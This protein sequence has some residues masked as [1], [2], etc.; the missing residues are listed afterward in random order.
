MIG[1]VPYSLVGFPDGASGKESTCPCRRSK[2]LRFNPWV[3]KILWRRKWKTTPIFLPEEFYGQ[4]SLAGY[5]PWSRKE[6]DS[7][8]HTPTFILMGGPQTGE[9]LHC[10]GSPTRV[11]RLS[12]TSGSP[13]QGPCPGK[14]SPQSI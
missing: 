14:I 5:S 2:R 1:Q 9:C 6:L 13:T 11:R 7:T 10:R 4:R 3:G 8:E 12:F